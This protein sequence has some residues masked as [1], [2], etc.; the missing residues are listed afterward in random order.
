MQCANIG[1]SEQD[2]LPRYC[3]MFARKN[4]TSSNV[5]NLKKVV[6]QSFF[7]KAKNE[8]INRCT[9]VVVL[10]TSDTSYAVK[11]CRPEHFF[12]FFALIAW[13]GSG[14]FW[15]HFPKWSGTI[16]QL[17]IRYEVTCSNRLLVMIFRVVVVVIVAVIA[18]W[19]WCCCYQTGLL[20]TSHLLLLRLNDFPRY[21]LPCMSLTGLS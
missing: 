9:L 12:F 2:V 10:C 1:Q 19:C 4:D 5:F 11:S 14:T 7:S 3:K 17:I 18:W 21:V 6:F 15:A 8:S 20:G 16:S 13:S